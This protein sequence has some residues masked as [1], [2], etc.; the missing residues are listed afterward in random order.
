MK[1]NKT[2]TCALFGHRDSPPEIRDTLYR[3][4]TELIADRRAGRFIVGCNGSFDRMALSVLRSLKQSYPHIEYSVVLSSMTAA[5]LAS[6]QLLPEETVFPEGMESVPPRY[7]ILRRNRWMIDSADLVAVYA[8]HPGGA[9]KALSAA[10]R[11][12]KQVIRIKT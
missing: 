10:V 12:K 6:E 8:V 5:P 11:M 7:A 2:Q 1:Q 4:L 3:I 9:A